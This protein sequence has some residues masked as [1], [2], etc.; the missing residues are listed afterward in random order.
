VSKKINKC[1]KGR[2]EFKREITY[3]KKPHNY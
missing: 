1:I 2:G 3:S